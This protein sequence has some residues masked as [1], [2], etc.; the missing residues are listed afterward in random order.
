MPASTSTLPTRLK[1]WEQPR[2]S[3]PG[4]TAFFTDP[5]LAPSP[6]SFDFEGL[7]ED[8]I[9]TSLDQVVSGSRNHRS[10]AYS[11]YQN[12]PP[13]QDAYFVEPS[14]PG[15]S[16]QYVNA[17]QGQG[18]HTQSY[19]PRQQNNQAEGNGNANHYFGF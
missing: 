18:Q 16:N 4:T 19:D 11:P 15:L 2:V 17:Q 12:Q 14:T 3:P 6:P 13:L 8:Q 5:P 10:P 9:P 7:T 1:P